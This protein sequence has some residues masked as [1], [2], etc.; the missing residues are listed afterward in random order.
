LTILHIQYPVTHP[1]PGSETTSFIT[2]DSSDLEFLSSPTAPDSMH[3]NMPFY[4]ICKLADIKL[5]TDK[6]PKQRDTDESLTDSNEDPASARV[7]K[8][9]CMSA[10]TLVRRNFQQCATFNFPQIMFDTK[11]RMPLPLPFFTHKSLHYI[12]DQLAMLPVCKVEADGIHKKGAILD[13]KKLSK[14]L[15]EELSPSFSQYTE[16]VAQMFNFQAQRDKDLPSDRE[17]WT[18]FCQ[19]LHFLFFENQHNA[20]EYHEEWKHVELDL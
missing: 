3:K 13:I 1:I 12:I 16:A 9:R 4:I 6:I 20:E 10:K 15:R 14:V 18:Q 19:E 8:C 5:A 7:S 17:T 2:I 11:D